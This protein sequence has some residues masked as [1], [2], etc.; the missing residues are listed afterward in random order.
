M[1]K[2]F[3]YCLLC[4]TFS[5][6]FTNPLRV[7]HHTLYVRPIVSKQ[8]KLIMI[9]SPKS[10]ILLCTVIDEENFKNV[11]ITTFKRIKQNDRNIFITLKYL[12]P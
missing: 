1:T 9:M 8:S 11:G 10:L 7:E 3:L 5:F 2:I 12:S 6:A 4:Y